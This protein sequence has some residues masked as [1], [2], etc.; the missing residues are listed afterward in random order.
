MCIDMVSASYDWD[1]EDKTQKQMTSSI[2]QSIEQLD[3]Q[4][5]A[6]KYCKVLYSTLLATEFFPWFSYQQAS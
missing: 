3:H 6:R 1:K 4:Q 5:L 2:E